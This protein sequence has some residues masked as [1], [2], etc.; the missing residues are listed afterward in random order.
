[1]LAIITQPHLLVDLVGRLA[2]EREVAVAEAGQQLDKP[3]ERREVLEAEEPVE[4]PAAPKRWIN[5]CL[6]YL[7]AIS[8]VAL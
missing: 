7:H 3:L 8:L 6:I 4:V 5:P 2:L 1:M